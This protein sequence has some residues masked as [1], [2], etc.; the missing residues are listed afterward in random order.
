MSLAF[1]GTGWAIAYRLAPEQQRDQVL[2]WM[3]PWSL[4]GLAW[5]ILL[6]AI[7]NIGISFELQPFMPQ[8]QA[9]Q[10]R[11][12]GWFSEFVRVLGT[13]LFVVSSYWSATTVAWA[14]AKGAR[15][16]Q[17]EQRSDF[18]ALCLTCF[19][20]MILPAAGI[21]LLGRWTTLGLAI[22][23]MLL[24]VAAYAPS[25]LHI[26][27]MPPMY[28]RAI[29]KMKFGK[30]SEAEW[31]IIRE[32]EKAEDDFQGWMMMADLYASHFHD[33]R[34]AEQTILDICEQPTTTN[35]QLSIALHKLAD[36][37][38]K[39]AG[40]PDA[41]RRALQMICDRTRGTLLAR[42]AQ[43]RI[44][45]LPGSAEEMRER[46]IARPIPLPALGDSL[47][48]GSTSHGSTAQQRAE[49]LETANSCVEKL[50]LDP[51]NV[52][53]RE[54]LARLLAERLDNA[55]QGIEQLDLLLGMP[56]QDA[57]RRAQW[58]GLTA[59]WQLKYRHDADSGRKTLE[60]LVS[61]FPSSVQAF[62]A[63]RRLE[64]LQREIQK[65]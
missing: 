24:P 27:K 14:L 59:A 26:K 49:A 37:Y 35:S 3:L 57:A 5:P 48:E 41:A 65:T 6:W 62:A 42:M 40:D 31:E 53:A 61:E 29:A 7:M 56:D 44:N 28:A 43:L 1:A 32:L 39:L 9:A 8:I 15:G 45:Q 17:G 64:L 47:D 38:L 33:M 36:W 51:N 46:E 13:G 4:K 20:A 18:K 50:K 58:L 16:L 30:Y 54:R 10:N 22:T 11:G 2:R 21:F 60:R 25:I 34:E 23:A 63:R 52:E 55:E 12:A 19:I